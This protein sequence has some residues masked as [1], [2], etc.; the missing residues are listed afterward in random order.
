MVSAEYNLNNIEK[1]QN[2]GV[3]HRPSGQTTRAF[4]EVVKEIVKA[5]QE[6]EDGESLDRT[7]G[8]KRDNLN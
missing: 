8:E 2:G 7:E 1:Q 4:T 3:M 6:E 5:M